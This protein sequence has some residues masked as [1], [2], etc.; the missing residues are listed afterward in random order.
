MIWFSE[1]LTAPTMRAKPRHAYRCRQGRPNWSR[2]TNCSMES[3][4]L[5]IIRYSLRPCAIGSPSCRTFL[6]VVSHCP[7][8]IVINGRLHALGFD[9]QA[10]RAAEAERRLAELPLRAAS[11]N[12]DRLQHWWCIEIARQVVEH[13]SFPPIPAGLAANYEKE[14]R[15]HFPACGGLIDRF[16]AIADAMDVS[17]PRNV[18]MSL[19]RMLAAIQREYA[20][21]AHFADLQRVSVVGPAFL[22]TKQLDDPAGSSLSSHFTILTKR[23]KPEKVDALLAR[24]EFA[25]RDDAAA[26]ANRGMEGSKAVIVFVDRCSGET[27]AVATSS[28][29]DDQ[30]LRS[31]LDESLK[32]PLRE[33][34]KYCGVTFVEQEEPSTAIP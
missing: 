33:L 27:R 12:D 13:S 23:E 29:V 34:L 5:K 7:L 31:A 32:E 19:R 6:L 10:V 24:A 4:V 9:S 25:V 28:V 1:R 22:T 16:R 14:G 30:D 26:L 21:Y 11:A 20:G 17:D 2:H 15:R 8:H 3:S 18:Q